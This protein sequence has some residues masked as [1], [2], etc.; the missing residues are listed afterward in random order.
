MGK[1]RLAGFYQ[2]CFC[3]YI[4]DALYLRCWG[5]NYGKLCPFKI[6]WVAGKTCVRFERLGCGLPL[7]LEGLLHH[8]FFQ[9]SIIKTSD[10]LK[11]CF[12]FLLWV[13]FLVCTRILVLYSIVH[14]QRF[15]RILR[16]IHITVSIEHSNMFLKSLILK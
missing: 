10:Q 4:S 9:K 8:W 3:V 16:Q 15:A 11:V 14:F 12:S 5:S 6:T 7:L 13:L 2:L 1:E